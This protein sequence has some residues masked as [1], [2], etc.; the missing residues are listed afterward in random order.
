M[1][2]INST[3]IQ[4]RCLLESDA[5]YL[6]EFYKSFSEKSAKVFSEEINFFSEDRKSLD[7]AVFKTQMPV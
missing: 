4:K 1:E 6:E 2:D 3:K 5:K 7:Y